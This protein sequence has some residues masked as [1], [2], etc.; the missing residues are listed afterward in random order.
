M[1]T[2]TAVRPS[3]IHGR[4][5]FATRPIAAGSV[6]GRCRVIPARSRSIYEL[7]LGDEVG[8]V[9]VLCR[10]RYI[11]HS[12]DANVVYY[13]DLTVVALRDI[14]AGEELLHGYGDDWDW[15]RRA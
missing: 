2:G 1:R 3:P 10:F 12:R 15:R 8:S 7:W 5:L 11:N 4:G 9:E 14:R 13:D 6:L